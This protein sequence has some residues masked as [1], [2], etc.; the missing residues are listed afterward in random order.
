M[1]Q[2]GTLMKHYQEAVD[3]HRANELDAALAS[4]MEVLRL[5]DKIPA[6][7]NNVAA[8]HLSQGNT[9]KAEAAWRKAVEHKPEYAEARYNLAVLLSE[10]GED[11]LEEAAVHCKIALQHKP[12][13]VQAHHLLGNIMVSQKRSDEAKQAYSTAENLAA[14]KL[15]VESSG[16][17]RQGAPTTTRVGEVQT[18]SLAGGRECK[19][20]TLSLRP[21]M[22]QVEGF[23]NDGECDAIIQLAQPRMKQVPTPLG[24]LYDC[25]RL[26]SVCHSPGASS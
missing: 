20:T 6:V 23:L 25:R 10:R 22:F 11:W 17:V 26:V 3:A 13:Y 15:S 7:H 8:I 19:L 9:Q 4:Y 2:K 1:D 24:R 12:D 14:A 18:L 21:L 16:D 5:S